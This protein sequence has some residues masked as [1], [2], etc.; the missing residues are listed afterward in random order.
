MSSCDC[1]V[2]DQR[3]G[4]DRHVLLGELA[5][6]DLGDVGVLGREHAV[7]RLEQQHVGAEAAVGGGDLRARRAGADDGERLR[8]LLQRPRALGA[9]HAPAELRAGDR[10]G[11]RARREDD[12]LAR[13]DLRAVDGDLALAGEAAGALDVVDLVLLEQAGDAAGERLDDLRAALG[14]LA[15]SRR[16]A[17]GTEMPNSSASSISCSTSATR[18]T[19]LAGMQA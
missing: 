6:G 12:R 16:C 4:V 13:L 15:R 17:P 10:L 1:D 7:E 8:Q 2:L 11:H 19:A 5:A 14:D 9:D 18:R 3:P